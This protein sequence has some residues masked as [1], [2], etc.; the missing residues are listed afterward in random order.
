MSDPSPPLSVDVVLVGA[1]FGGLCAAIKLREAGRSVLI[2]E[3]GQDVGG[4]W[5]DN[6]YPGAACDVQSHLYSF[7]F[8]PKT[9]W[10][11]RFAGWEEIL[12][13]IRGVVDQF[14]L[15]PVIRLG[16]E[17][18]SA[19]FDASAARWTVT[20]QQ[21]LRVS[22]RFAILATGP[23]HVPA[24]PDLPGL[25]QFQGKVFHSARWDHD[26][27]LTGKDVVSIGTGGSAIQYVPEIA[28]IVRKLMVF[29]RSAAWVVPRDNREYSAA[30]KRLYAAVPLARAAHRAALYWRN[31]SRGLV[32]F[33]PGVARAAGKL[34]T[35]FLRMQVKD[36]ALAA[37]LTPDYTLGCKRVLISNVYFPTFNRPNVE[38]VT[39]R[40]QE[41]RAHSIVTTDGVERPC[42]CLILGTGFVVDP[43][44]YMKGFEVVG[45][46]G[47]R[48]ADDWKDAPQAYL[49]VTVAGYPNLFQLVGP[50]T[51]LG[52]NSIVFM[53]E[54]QV[55]YLVRLM[56]LI[57]ARQADYAAV[58]ADAQQAFNDD[59][60]ANLKGTVWETGCA[61]WY[62]TAE[63][64]NITLWPWSTWRYWLRLRKPDPAAFE[65]G[66][67]T[68]A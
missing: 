10:S 57:D 29:Q 19:T 59:L 31:E 28:P 23:L 6:T 11:R 33:T 67:A 60:Q 8:A 65:F 62:H 44:I 52:H 22:A 32:M 41:L 47:R 26:Y 21:G 58:R 36:P 3:K 34:A 45:L 2:L 38:L 64:R 56:A 40:I 43:R 35:R 37:R 27:D 55:H 46:G 63:G 50:N 66:K 68:R 61:S 20:T 51:G 15:R 13:Y 12:G 30:K 53:I 7:S 4:T 48:L 25:D 18:T 54:V 16:Q 5:R 49:G 9:D 42:D 14:N 1:G 39:D 24:I 17:V